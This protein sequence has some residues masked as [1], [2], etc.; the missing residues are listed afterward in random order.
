MTTPR[1]LMI[2]AMDAAPEHTVEQG[3]LSLA[4]AGAEVIDLLTAQAVRLEGEDIVPG[5]R[6][7]LGDRLLE[8]AASSLVREAPYESLDDWLWRRGRGLSSAYLAA[9]EG[10]GQLTRQRRRWM[11][12][13]T[14]QTLIDSPDHRQ[15]EDRWTSDEPVLATLAASLGIRDKRTGDPP[16][17]ADDAVTTVLAAVHDALT[18]LEAERQRRA[19]EE[20]AFDNVWRGE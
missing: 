18:E 2:I 13:R 20:A 4:L 8:E 14:S 6:P 1:D 3:N 7:T 17:V 15:A 11:P 12:F 19:I 10:E 9:L 5:Y 16:S